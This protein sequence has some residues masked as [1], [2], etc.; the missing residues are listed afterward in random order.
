MKTRIGVGQSD[1]RAFDQFFDF[2][3]D[4]SSTGT[5]DHRRACRGRPSS[6]RGEASA[7]ADENAI[8][9]LHEDQRDFARG[10]EEKQ[11]THSAGR[12][13]PP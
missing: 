13:L 6:S 8:S 4:V 9:R 10:H 1:T 12:R 3:T 7:G 5:M 11:R 2:V